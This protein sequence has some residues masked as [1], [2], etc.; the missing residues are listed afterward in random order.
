[1]EIAAFGS[2]PA[3]IQRESFFHGLQSSFNIVGHFDRQSLHDFKV[4]RSLADLIRIHFL[5]VGRVIKRQPSIRDFCCHG[6]VLW[7][8]GT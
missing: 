5:A 7:P 6:D 8:L 4:R 1:M 2:H 3:D